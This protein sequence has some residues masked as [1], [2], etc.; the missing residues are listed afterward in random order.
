MAFIEKTQSKIRMADGSLKSIEDLR[1][2]DWIVDRD[3][4]PTHIKCIMKMNWRDTF[5]F[6]RI[7]DEITVSTDQLFLGIDGKYYLYGGLD[8]KFYIKYN[9][10]TQNTDS[11]YGAPSFRPFVGLDDSV[12]RNLEI[13]TKLVGENGTITVTSIEPVTFQEIPPQKK[14]TDFYKQKKEDIDVN[15]LDYK[16]YLTY[17]P[18]TYRISAYRTGIMFVNGYACMGLPNNDWNYDEDDFELPGSYEI[19]TDLEKNR[20]KKIRT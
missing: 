15:T 10:G 1:P 8:N 19:I 7:N 5:E 13:G 9:E 2:G 16:D 20:L 18:L 11:M 6:I 12:I 17:S 14:F 4:F 3:R